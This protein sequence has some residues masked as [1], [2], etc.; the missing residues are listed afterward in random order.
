MSQFMDISWIVINLLII[1]LSVGAFAIKYTKYY[2]IMIAIDLKTIQSYV[3]A[4]VHKKFRIFQINLNKERI[5]TL[6]PP[7]SLYI[8]EN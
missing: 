2:K 1:N 4:E 8:W 5:N 6:K 7:E 3:K